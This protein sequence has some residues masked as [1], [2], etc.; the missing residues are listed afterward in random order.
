MCWSDNVTKFFNAV[1]L[2]LSITL[3]TDCPVYLYNLY[4]NMTNLFTIVFKNYAII[5]SK[6]YE[7][8][9][10]RAIS[11]M[12][13]ERFGGGR[14]TRRLEVLLQLCFVFSVYNCYVCFDSK[15]LNRLF[16]TAPLKLNDNFTHWLS[17]WFIE[18]IQTTLF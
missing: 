12:F 7:W 4:I 14:G 11:L 1:P 18:F 17:G 5:S 8:L 16:D 2:K 13:E 3:P 10:I 15:K 6:D 9:Q